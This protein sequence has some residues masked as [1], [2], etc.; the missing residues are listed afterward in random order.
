[1]KPLYIFDLDGTLADAEHRIH[2]IS[3]GK[4]DWRN[5]FAECVNDKPIIPAVTTMTWLR[6]AGAEVWIWTGRSDEIRQETIS[7]LWMH[8]R[9]DFSGGA[10][11]S[12]MAPERFMMRRAGD[13]RPDHEL[14]F[15]WLADLEPPE[16]SRLTAVFEDRTRVVQMWRKHGVP[17]YQVAQGDF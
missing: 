11:S 13:H 16:R 17:C 6:H 3:K 5:F 8:C 2:L 15:E 4:K 14:K 12:F 9:L 1:V 10:L 7:W